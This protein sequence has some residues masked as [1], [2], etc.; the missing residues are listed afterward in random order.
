M[1]Q[2]P[3]QGSKGRKNPALE[4]V[5]SM[6]HESTIL[7]MMGT[8]WMLNQLAENGTDCELEWGLFREE[9]YVR[10]FVSV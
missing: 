10:K 9:P 7:T 4:P 8:V 2:G 3:G 5:P 1:N 6:V